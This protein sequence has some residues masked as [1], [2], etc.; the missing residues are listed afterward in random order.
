MLETEQK[1]I[2]N[3]LARLEGFRLRYYIGNQNI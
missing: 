2:K 3:I 1:R